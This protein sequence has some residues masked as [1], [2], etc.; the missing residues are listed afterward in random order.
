MD[1]IDF[2]VGFV[3]CFV[4]IGDNGV[5]KLILFDLFVGIFLLMVGEVWFD[6]F[7][8]VVYVW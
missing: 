3:D 2:V 1:C 4:V 5:G 6:F 8:G 7:G